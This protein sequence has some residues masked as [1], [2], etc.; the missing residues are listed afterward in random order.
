MKTFFRRKKYTSS[1]FLF[2]RRFEIFCFFLSENPDIEGGK[3]LLKEIIPFYT[4]STAILPPLS[5]LK[6]KSIFFRRKPIYFSKKTQILNVL[7]TFTISIAFYGKF[8][9]IWWKKLTF[10]HVAN[11]CWFVYA[12]SIGKHRV[13]KR[14]YLRGR[15]CFP[16]FQYGS[17]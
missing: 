16:Y 17:K 9:T 15:F 12:S 14:T 1:Y 3:D 5:I 7:R 8:A 4:H 11:R 10:R 13:K 6:K 2:F